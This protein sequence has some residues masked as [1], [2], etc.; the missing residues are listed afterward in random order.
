M[1]I[2]AA[3]IIGA[4]AFAVIASAAPSLEPLMPYFTD[5]HV[6]KGE[7]AV[8]HSAPYIISLSQK[9]NSS[10]ICGG[11]LIAKDWIITAAH[12]IP[13]RDAVGMGVVAG[14]H[15]RG[16]LDETTQQRVVDFGRVHEMFDKGVGPYD[17][18]LLHV[19][20]PFEFN[21]NVQPASLPFF[22]EIPT[23]SSALYGWGQTKAWLLTAARSL[24]TVELEVLEWD[25]CK[26]ALG[27]DTQLH[28][29][30]VC[31]SSNNA[32]ISACNG[33]SGGPLV[34]EIDGAP[35]TLIGIVSW[36]YIPCGLLNMP[37]IFTRMSAHIDW[38]I[39]IQHAFYT[40]F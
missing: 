22:N 34:Q 36:G 28:E 2:F 7:E 15:K 1:K 17:I 27:E 24:Q 3:V 32:G 38:V 9:D 37:S 18:A 40:L 39:K 6:I 19:S 25:D 5:N 4:F 26:T 21:V 14:L 8:P 23:G 33:D 12:C 16:D 35:S 10:H 20:V 31:T 30:N 13:K 11:T 29:T